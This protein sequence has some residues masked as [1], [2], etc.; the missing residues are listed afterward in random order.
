MLP[1]V[2]QAGWVTLV[3]DRTLKLEPS[4]LVPRGTEPTTERAGAPAGPMVD[5]R[6][7]PAFGMWLNEK[8]TQLRFAAT[9]WNAGDSPLIIDGFR[10]EGEDED[11]YQYFYDAAGNEVGHQQ[12]DELHYH[13]ANHDH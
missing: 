8:G 2:I 13:R 12:V 5:L 11:A 7:L 1:E 4:L 6:S 3:F 10:R 9:T